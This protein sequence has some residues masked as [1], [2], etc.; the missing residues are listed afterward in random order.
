MESNEYTAKDIMVLSGPQGIRKRPAMY[1]GST[2]GKGFLHLLYEVL[3]NAIDEALAGYAKN[4]TITLAKDEDVDTAE[5]SDNGRGIPIDI[6]PKDGRPALEVI[7][8]SIHTGAKFENKVYK[9]AGGLHGVGLTVVNSLSE[10]TEVTIKRSGKVYRQTFSRGAPTTALEIIGDC[11][12]QENGTTI[13]FKPDS[14][15]FSTKSFDSFELTE[16]LKE[17]AYLNPGISISY[18]DKREIG[19]EHQ[20]NFSSQR[21]IAEFVEALRDSKEPLTKEIFISKESDSVKVELAMQYVNDYSEKL[22]SFVNRIKTPEGGTHVIGFHTALTRAISNYM[23]KNKK[24]GKN[25]SEIEGDDT[26]EGLIAVLSILMQNA[27]FEGQTKEKLGNISIKSIID[28]VVY[29]ALSTYLEENPGDASGIVRKVLNTAEARE[30]AKRARDLVR[31]KSMFEGALLPGKLSDCTESDPEKAEI[32]IVEGESAAG[33]SKQGRDRHYQAILPLKGKILNV[34]KASDEKIFNNAEL[35]TMVTAFGT[36]IKETFNP[37][38]V[39]YKKI[40]ML[41]DADVDGSHIRTLLM[42]FFYRYMRALI[43]RGNIYIAQPPLYKVSKGK[44]VQYV[45]SDSE[46]NAVLKKYDGNAAVQRYKGLGEMNPEQLWETTMDPSRRV[47]KKISIKDAQ[48]ADALFVT[49]MGMDVEQRRHFLE[50][51]ASEVSF[52]DI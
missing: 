28:S 32:F 13:K 21:G 43:D 12:A 14:E 31:K 45:Y 36:G 16:R 25:A 20:M 48:L 50:E 4:I 8:T 10:K 27:E 7:M 42:T 30:S 34:E 19:N 51:H 38:A 22:L 2:S 15:I 9:V 46:L 29:P 11:P 23:Q 3:D 44:E 33:S 39:R 47:L 5:V 17:L 24:Q 37:D 52:L 35:H 1:I 18:L 41:T 26:R 40:V 49:L 6:M